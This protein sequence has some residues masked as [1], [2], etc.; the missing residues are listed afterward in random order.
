MSP[1]GTGPAVGRLID[2]PFEESRRRELVRRLPDEDDGLEPGR[3]LSLS[4]GAWATL[5][6]PL[7]ADS[8]VRKRLSDVSRRLHATLEALLELPRGCG[9]VVAEAGGRPY[10][11]R[12]SDRGRFPYPVRR[13]SDASAYGA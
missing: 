10:V 8:A 7:D 3:G 12:E 6:D 9:I 11:D 5:Q 4:G 13:I 1:H 2:L